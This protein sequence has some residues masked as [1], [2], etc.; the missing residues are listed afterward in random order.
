MS[1]NTVTGAEELRPTVSDG[2]GPR[3]QVAGIKRVFRYDYDFTKDGGAISTITLRS[4]E[5]VP[6][7][8]IALSAVAD[9]AA[10]VTGGGGATIALQLEA[11]NDIRNAATIATG[12][13]DT[14]GRKAL[15]PVGTA[16]TSVKTT[17]VRDLKLVVAV[18]A[19]TAGRFSVFVEG[20]VA[21]EA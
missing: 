11:A 9:V 14:T 4:A 17:V 13:F 7:N 6:A 21:R 5:K 10:A 19:L 2:T 16:A 8:F 1:V 18:A 20:Y 15:I 3:A 12:G